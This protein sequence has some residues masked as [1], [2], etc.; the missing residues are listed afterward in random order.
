[1]ACSM[2]TSLGRQ[3]TEGFKTMGMG[4]ASASQRST[5]CEDGVAD[6]IYERMSSANAVVHGIGS[7]RYMTQSEGLFGTKHKTWRDRADWLA[8][9]KRSRWGRQR[10][11]V[12]GHSIRC[13]WQRSGVDHGWQ[14]GTV[15][16]Q[17]AH[18]HQRA[19]Q[20]G[21]QQASG[22]GRLD[23]GL[24]RLCCGCIG[25]VKAAICTGIQAAS[26]TAADE[27]EALHH[28]TILQQQHAWQRPDVK[29]GCWKQLLRWGCWGCRLCRR[30]HVQE[31]GG[32]EAARRLGQ[33]GRKG[34]TKGAPVCGE[35]RHHQAAGVGFQALLQLCR[36]AD[37]L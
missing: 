21:M 16:V 2:M 13:A 15:G 7:T 22:S 12:L 9:L 10:S 27:L 33:P 6:C 28:P 30:G 31:Q 4:R 14:R 11:P 24:P 25:G 5:Q 20:R 37:L 34:R 18:T 23:G 8:L 19:K 32:G 1:M 35:V 3:G 36:R 29:G 17:Q 26:Q